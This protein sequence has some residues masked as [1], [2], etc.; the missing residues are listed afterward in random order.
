MQS[1]RQHHVDP[2]ADVAWAPGGFPSAYLYL[3]DG[4]TH[5]VARHSVAEQRLR[6]RG[7]FPAA[8]LTFHRPVEPAASAR[9]IE[10]LRLGDAVQRFGQPDRN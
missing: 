8:V 2:T 9:R 10:P 3:L 5:L 6:D 1:H 4:K 7:A